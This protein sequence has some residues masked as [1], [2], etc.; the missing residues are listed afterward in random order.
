MAEVNIGFTEDSKPSSRVLKPPGGNHSNIF[1]SPDAKPN[2]PRPKYN[3][4]N[5]S[6]LNAVM[7]TVDPNIRSNGGSGEATNGDHHPA[8]QP[9]VNNITPSS[10]AQSSDANNQ[11][12]GRVRVPPGGFSS[13]LW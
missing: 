5:S 9:A 6:N 7:G 1:D 4:Q 11:A 8:P 12:G 3:Q 2:P 10:N 13:G